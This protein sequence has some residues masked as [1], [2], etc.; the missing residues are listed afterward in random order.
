[1]FTETEESYN[2]NYA[3]IVN[4]PPKLGPFLNCRWANNEETL[5]THTS[6]MIILYDPSGKVL[7][8]LDNFDRDREIVC[9]VPCNNDKQVIVATT[10]VHTLDVIDLC[11]KE[12]VMSYEESEPIIN[13]LTIPGKL[14]YFNIF[15]TDFNVKIN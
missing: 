8:V 9:C 2:N 10:G 4:I 7:K 13:I 3:N 5:I 14:L 1:M 15:K 12:K 11:T 6:K